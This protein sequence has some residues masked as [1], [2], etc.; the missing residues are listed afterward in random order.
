M[1]YA[2]K[3]GIGFTVRKGYDMYAYHPLSR[4]ENARDIAC[5]NSPSSPWTNIVYALTRDP[6]EGSGNDS[7]EST[8]SAKI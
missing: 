2:T 8:I 4:T 3:A 6:K 7:K 5:L 1:N